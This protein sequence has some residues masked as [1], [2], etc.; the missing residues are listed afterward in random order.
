MIQ[1]FG[2]DMIERC[3]RDAELRFMIDQSGNYVLDFAGDDAPPDFRV[4]VCAEGSSRDVLFIQGSPRD[5]Y[6][7]HAR[8]RLEAAAQGWNSSSRWPKAFVTESPRGIRIFAEN[9]YPL[10]AGVH[11][12][13]VN[14]LIMSNLHA[15]DKLF[16]TS[17]EAVV[18]ESADGVEH[19]LG[20]AS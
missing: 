2:P 18:S 17:H 3:L 4:F 7:S 20:R 10:G 1:Q 15:A 6:P 11:Q 9:S 12:Q 19:W 16:S 14:E 5:P 8:A 13:L